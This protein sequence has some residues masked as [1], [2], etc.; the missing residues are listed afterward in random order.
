MVQFAANNVTEFAR[1]AEMVQP[2]CDG[3][4]L[5]CG[6][7][8]SW[9]CGEGIGAQL[10]HDRQKVALMVKGAKDRCGKDFCVSV[11]IRVHKDL[12]YVPLFTPML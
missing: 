8:Q 9:A 2:Y 5:N 3:V 12:R 4:D 10:M 11:K 7:P 1:A 6:C